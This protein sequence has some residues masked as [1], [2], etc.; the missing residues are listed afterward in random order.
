LTKSTLDSRIIVTGPPPSFGITTAVLG[1][2]AVEDVVWMVQN[3]IWPIPIPARSWLVAK[4]IVAG[5]TTVGR[6]EKIAVLLAA[7]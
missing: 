3:A 1:V 4:V 2:N 5:P 6:F 7:V